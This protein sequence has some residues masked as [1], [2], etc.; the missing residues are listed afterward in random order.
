[1]EYIY[2][3]GENGTCIYNFNVML[4]LYNILTINSYKN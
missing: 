3:N 2:E 1:M 4:C